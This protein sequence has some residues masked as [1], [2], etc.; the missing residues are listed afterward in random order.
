MKN[1]DIT[2]DADSAPEGRVL[3]R[4]RALKICAA[5]GG[6]YLAAPM[7]NC[8]RFQAFAQTGATYSAHAIDLVESSLVI[9]MLSALGG[10]RWEKMWRNA[11][12]I[13]E[14]DFQWLKSSGISVFHV[15]G[16]TFGSRAREYAFKEFASLNSLIL[17]KSA[18]A[19][20][21]D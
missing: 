2:P 16:T 5:A 14:S 13:G 6:L 1:T 10:E 4:R 3:S 11:N 19:M 15:A 17:Y 7:V 12:A 18:H 21:I 8:G 20:R 9:D